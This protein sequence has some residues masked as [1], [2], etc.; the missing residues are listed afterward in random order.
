[1]TLTKMVKEGRRGNENRLCLKRTKKT[2]KDKIYK[3]K[4]AGA[5]LERLKFV[6]FHV[7]WHKPSQALGKRTWVIFSGN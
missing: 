1:M 7:K 4:R 6:K 3:N 5:V 2:Y